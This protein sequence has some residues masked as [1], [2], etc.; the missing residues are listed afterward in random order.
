MRTPAFWYPDCGSGVPWQARLLAPLS[1]LYAAGTR[2]RVAQE[3][4]HRASLPVICVGNVNAGGTGKTPTVIA[5][6]E[7][8]S[9]RGMTP[10]ILSRGYGGRA[11]GPRRVDPSRHGAADVGDE[12]LLMAAF[13]PVWVADDRAEG[14]RALESDGE[15]DVVLLDDGFQDPSV[16]KTLSIVVVDA[17][18]GFGNG[19]VFPAGPLREPVEE[20]MR[21]ASALVSIGGS[22]DQ[23]RFRGPLGEASAVPRLEAHLEPLRTGLQWPGLRVLAFAGIGRP[24]KFFRSLSDLGAELLRTVPLGDHQPLTPALMA[25]L[26]AEAMARGAQ[27]VTTEKD[28]V[29]LPAAFRQKVVTLPVRLRFADPDALDAL[30]NVATT[31]RS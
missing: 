14:L 18:A 12:P 27:L 3:P 15:A 5:L 19:R 8:L 22:G 20:A 2:R 1:M 21:R 6:A 30:L 9:A 11:G 24:E 29:R 17:A 31:P 13:A 28:A 16:A 10:A 4:R 7:R 25:R 23:A 26:E